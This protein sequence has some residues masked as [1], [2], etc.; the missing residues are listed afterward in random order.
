M[1]PMQVAQSQTASQ[2]SCEVFVYLAVE[3]SVL[4]I[5]MV[6]PAG[7]PVNS[8]VDGGD[9]SGS[10]P[11]GANE[12]TFSPASPGVL[13]LKLKAQVTPSGVASLITDKVHFTVNA[14]SGSTMAWDAANPGGKPTASGDYLLATVTFTG[15]PAN[16]TSFGSKLAAVYCDSS[17]QDEEPYEVFFPKSEKNHPGPDSGTTPN[18]FYYWNQSLGNLANIA[19]GGNG[20]TKAGE[21]KGMTDWSYLA[22]QDKVTRFLYDGAADKAQWINP[23]F[24]PWTGIDAFYNVYLHESKHVWQIST[25]DNDVP[26][27]A[28]TPWQY[29]WSWN[30]GLANHNHETLGADGLP[31]NPNADDDG[32]GI[33]NNLI[34]TGR[35]EL[36]YGGDDVRKCDSGWDTWPLSQGTMPS[37]PWAQN[38]PN[39][40]KAY[41]AMSNAENTQ[42]AKDWGDPGKQH[43]TLNKH[44]D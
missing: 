16:N 39:E 34:T 23:N 13:T 25:Y 20:L 5:D 19:Y 10:V 31:G 44:D 4:K 12:F 3:A 42:T 15:L 9:G 21:V 29:G 33:T 26:V 40:H 2:G 35:G 28:G 14:I 37:P 27:A 1:P 32:D 6:T 8:A 43:A 24:G 22:A 11:D 41:E 7:D 38:T 36:G 18:W 30:Q 17:K